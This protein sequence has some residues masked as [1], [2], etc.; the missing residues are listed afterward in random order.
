MS[1]KHDILK[2]FDMHGCLRS[3]VVLLLLHVAGERQAIYSFEL[4]ACLI[5]RI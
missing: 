1:Q 4:F 5:C 2:V 3:V